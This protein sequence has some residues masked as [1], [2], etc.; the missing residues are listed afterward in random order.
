[1]KQIQ[2][3]LE[4]NLYFPVFEAGDIVHLEYGGHKPVKAKILTCFEFDYFHDGKGH[5]A[6]YCAVDESKVIH[7]NIWG[8]CIKELK[9]CQTNE[10]A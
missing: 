3:T 5:G 6:T 10:M 1:M 8:F 2:D 9:G 7:D 4:P